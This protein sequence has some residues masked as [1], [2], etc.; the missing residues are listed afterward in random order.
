MPAKSIIKIRAVSDTGPLLS[1]F[2]CGRIDILKH[3]HEAIYITHEQVAELQGHGAGK[4]VDELVKEGFLIVVSLSEGEEKE[5]L[6]VAEMIAGLAKDKDPK[7]HL[8][9][10]K[11]MMLTMRRE[12]GARYI[13]LEER[14]AR[15]V[16]A[17]LGLEYTGFVGVLILAAQQGLISPDE[18]KKALEI[19]RRSGTF[20]S[21]RL[22]DE[23]LKKARGER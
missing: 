13:L 2:Q 19:C 3:F 23:A 21:Q 8:P 6:K 11:A 18:V 14:P 15:I 12:L 16:A 1:A 17:H 10:A 9:E 7:V 4:E 5:A 20:Y 22:I